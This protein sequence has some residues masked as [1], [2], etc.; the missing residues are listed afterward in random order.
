MA[1]ASAARREL[2]IAWDEIRE[3][4]NSISA[5]LEDLCRQ[6]RESQGGNGPAPYFQNV[7]RSL[8]T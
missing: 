4:T 1:V 7:P 3:N 2:H 6:V 5:R 8:P